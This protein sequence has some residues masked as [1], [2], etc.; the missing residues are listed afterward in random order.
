MDVLA[1]GSQ[2]PTAGRVVNAADEM[3]GFERFR[4]GWGRGVKNLELGVLQHPILA[5]AAGIPVPYGAPVSNQ[6]VQDE[7]ALSAPLMATSG[8]KWGNI[9]GTGVTVAPTGLVPGAGTLLGAGAIG[10]M[11]G[12][13]QP[14]ASTGEQVQNTAIG[15]VAAPAGI[16][17]GRALGAGYNLV[18]STLEPFFRGGQERIAGRTLQAFAGGEQEAAQA[19]GTI[20]NAGSVL[21]G[22][23]P[24]TAELANNAG[25]AQLERQLRNNAD[26]TT[27]F[28]ARDAA[29]RTALTHGLESIAGTDATRAAAVTA[30]TQ[31]S[32]P[33]Y[34]AAANASVT[35]DT[36]LQGLLKR[37]AM[38]AAWAKAEQI[39]ANSGESIGT[40]DQPTGKAI[41]YLKMGLSDMANTGPMQ[42]IGAHEAG[43]IKSTLTALNNWIDTNVPALRAADD[44]FRQASAPINQMDIGGQLR[45]KLVPALGDFGNSTRLNSA[46]FANAVR[47]G[48]AIAA[49][50]TGNARSTLA[51]VLS[52]NQMTTVQQ[53]GEQ[54]ARRSNANEMGRA[55]GSNTSQNLVSQNLLRQILGPLGL[56]ESMTE[57]V[58]G[59]TLG[60]TLLR[61]AQW[62][63]QSGEKRVMNVLADAALD[64]QKARSLLLNK[65]INSALSKLMWTNQGVLGSSATS[66]A[67]SRQ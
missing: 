28:G 4:A 63:A 24:T 33:L 1:D 65:Q 35:P 15:G 36:V 14:S 48:D 59:S 6:D 54:L 25:L 22:V 64:P 43:A 5:N 8:G 31:V 11:M 53:V 55:V 32:K 67:N 44:A 20:S 40:L 13:L 62:A 38:Q 3:S 10:D 37:P 61:P 34:D 56:P 52:P 50:V 46:S 47:N 30:R 41:Q 21:P 17:A 7:R 27:Q 2:V 16:L 12:A 39:A 57:R 23:Q 49:D 45:D 19:A 58:A 18:K 26:L 29:N 51:G 66:L 42:G 9:I 60:E